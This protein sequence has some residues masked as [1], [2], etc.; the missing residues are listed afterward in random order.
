MSND[1]S[2]FSQPTAASTLPDQ[3]IPPTNLTLSLLKPDNESVRQHRIHETLDLG[4]YPISYY[5]QMYYLQ[6]MDIFSLGCSILEVLRDG[7]P[8]MNFETYLKFKKNE[9]SFDAVV[10]E[11]CRNLEQGECLKAMLMAMLS[12]SPDD[13]P[14]IERIVEDFNKI[15]D[16]DSYSLI[17][18][19]CS[20]FSTTSFF[21]PDERIVLIHSI[22]KFIEH[23]ERG[24]VLDFKVRP[25]KCF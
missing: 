17:W 18:H 11:T 7:K 8:M 10:E 24:T 4:R 6:K 21:L 5:D 9:V 22:L 14:P 13:R 20:A 19:C 2:S 3:S 1:L 25:P 15:I 16:V 12:S 23:E